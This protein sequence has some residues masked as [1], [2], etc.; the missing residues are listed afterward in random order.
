VDEFD[1]FWNAMT[2]GGGYLFADKDGP[3]IMQAMRDAAR[4]GSR[5][6]EPLELESIHGEPVMLQPAFIVA[7][8]RHTH[9]SLQSIKAFNDWHDRV[10]EG[11]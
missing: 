3:T 9:D 6:V 11:W 10:K 2:L 8:T 7:C 1:T 4:A 5:L